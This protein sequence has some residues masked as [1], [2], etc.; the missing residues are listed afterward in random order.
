MNGIEH[1]VVLRQRLAH[2]L[3]DA[4]QRGQPLVNRVQ[5]LVLTR[6]CRLEVLQI[7]TYCKARAAASLKVHT[8]TLTLR[9]NLHAFEGLTGKQQLGIPS[10]TAGWPR[11]AYNT[12]GC[13]PCDGRAY[14]RRWSRP[15]GL[16]TAATR[17]TPQAAARPISSD[18]CMHSRGPECRPEV[19]AD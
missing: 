12:R 8:R 1:N 10:G 2:G 15:A 11:C 4:A 3:P 6:L 7:H 13:C 18:S 19:K 5:R 16:C 9:E 14:Q 17:V